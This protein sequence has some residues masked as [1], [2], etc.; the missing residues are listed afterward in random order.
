MTRT[1][2]TTAVAMFAAATFFAST[3]Q[4]CISCNYVPEVVN[5]PSKGKTYQKKRVVIAASPGAVQPSNKRLTKPQRVAKAEPV[6]RKVETAKAEP[7][8]PVESNNNVRPISTAALLEARSAPAAKPEVV[9][10]LG[11]KKFF[12][13]IGTTVTV[14]CE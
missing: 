9:A 13:T 10:D 4:A 2:L 6:A 12:P 11:C 3:A 5:T 7:A 1:A 14:P 8:K